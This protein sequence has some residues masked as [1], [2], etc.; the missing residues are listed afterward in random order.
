MKKIYSSLLQDTMIAIG[1]IVGF[2]AIM[3]AI[4]FLLGL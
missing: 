2:F 4:A 3:V 1:I